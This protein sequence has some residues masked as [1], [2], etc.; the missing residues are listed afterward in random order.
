MTF[1]L[2]TR[3]WPPTAG[4]NRSP[5]L[6]DPI[7]VGVLKRDRNFCARR[8]HGP[9]CCDVVEHCRLHFRLLR[10]GAGGE[11]PLVAVSHTA[12]A[13]IGLDLLWRRRSGRIG[14]DHVAKEGTVHLP[15]SE[16]EPTGWAALIPRNRRSQRLGCILVG[17]YLRSCPEDRT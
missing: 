17:G 15:S 3:I 7:I 6:Y 2:A 14:R 1:E 5:D 4:E 11:R 16:I 9:E 8:P 10:H 13:A 12:D